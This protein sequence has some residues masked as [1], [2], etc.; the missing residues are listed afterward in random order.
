MTGFPHLD[1]A[2]LDD[3]TNVLLVAPEVGQSVES[4]FSELLVSLESPPDHVVGVT[5]SKSPWDFLEPWRRSFPHGSASF[6]FVSTDG[7]ARSTAAD[8]GGAADA[9][10]GSDVT[11]V[12]EV[13][14]VEAFGQ[15]VADEVAE[16]GAG[17]AV[18]FYSLTDLLEYVDVETAFDFLHVVL[19]RVRRNGARGVY[20]VDAG[21]HDPETV[22]KLSTLFDLVV[23]FDRNR[24]PGDAGTP[25]GGPS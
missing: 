2:A 5:M 6:S 15:T 22:V 11:H 10:P 18:C 7:V 19:S 1:Q 16:H 8:A 14:P 25:A 24:P 3:A 23:E 12:D 9:G 13:L 20:H 4:L 17:T 21:V